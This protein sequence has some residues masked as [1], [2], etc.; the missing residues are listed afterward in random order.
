VCV[1][2]CVWTLAH[3]CVLK[4]ILPEDA[5]QTEST[6]AVVVLVVALVVGVVV[7]IVLGRVDQVLCM[8]V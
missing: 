5:E 7:G 6:V 8:W 1:C 3:A 4:S 2:V